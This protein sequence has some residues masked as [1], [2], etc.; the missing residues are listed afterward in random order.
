M[1]TNP[2]LPQTFVFAYHGAVT[3]VT[4]KDANDL[5]TVCVIDYDLKECGQCPVCWQEHDGE[6]VCSNCG[7]DMHGNPRDEN[8]RAAQ[9]AFQLAERKENERPEFPQGE[10]PNGQ[11]Y[12][13]DT[14]QVARCAGCQR[15]TPANLLATVKGE[16]DRLYCPN[17]RDGQD[18]TQE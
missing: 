15:V 9:A 3:A 13:G 7:F 5:P 16:G 1:S 6:S 8:A 2:N 14:E 17:C 18:Y 11:E 12:S 4:D 10:F